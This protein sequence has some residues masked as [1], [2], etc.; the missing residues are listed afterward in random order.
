LIASA[1]NQRTAA[2]I[3]TVA[4]FLLILE[5]VRRKRLMERYALLWLLA[6]LVMLAMAAW[7]RPLTSLASLIGIYYA[8]SAL[9]ALAFCF[10]LVLLVH[11]SLVVSRL[12][13]QNKI[14]AQRLSLLQR[15]IEDQ[16]ELSEQQPTSKAGST[17][18][19][20]PH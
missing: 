19:S 4:L 9:F 12:S 1:I 2:I 8:P 16:A 10:V 7:E 14:L 13:D 11:F 18:L 15:R 5:F 17:E 3:V 20:A 6:T